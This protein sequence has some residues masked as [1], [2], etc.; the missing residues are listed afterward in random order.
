[1]RNGV[2]ISADLSIA[3]VLRL[4]PVAVDDMTGQAQGPEQNQCE[5]ER[6][7]PPICPGTIGVHNGSG[8]EH[9]G[10]CAIHDT[11]VA[12]EMLTSHASVARLSIEISPMT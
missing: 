6:R 12:L 5:D 8:K 7:P 10:P 11:H 1:M 3:P 2:H 9:H 4:A